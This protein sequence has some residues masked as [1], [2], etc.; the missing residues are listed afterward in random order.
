[1]DGGAR[2]AHDI[3]EDGVYEVVRIAYVLRR[4]GEEDFT[5][6]VL[7]CV[8]STLT[9]SICLGIFARYANGFDP[10][11]NEAGL[12]GSAAEFSALI[13]YN[14]NRSWVSPREPRVLKFH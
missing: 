12:K 14:T 2:G 11:H 10:Q 5:G 7:G 6:H 4:S 3:P 13:V 9:H 8:M 1:M